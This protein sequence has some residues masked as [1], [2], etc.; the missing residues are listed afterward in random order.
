MIGIGIS[1]SLLNYPLGGF[2]LDSLEEDARAIFSIR[3]LLTSYT[4]ALVR[5]RRDNDDDE[6]DFGYDDNGDLDTVAVAAW[7]GA[8]DAF[9]VTWYDQ[10]GNGYD[11]AAS[12]TKSYQPQYIASGINSKPVLRNN[13]GASGDKLVVPDEPFRGLSAVTLCA[14]TEV[15]DGRTGYAIFGLYDVT[16]A[17]YGA[18]IAAP[19]VSNKVVFW[20]GN[21]NVNRSLDTFTLTDPHIFIGKGENEA[22]SRIYVDGTEVNYDAGKQVN[23]TTTQSGAFTRDAAIGQMDSVATSHDSD[24]DFAELIC[25]DSALSDADR[26]AIEADQSTYFNI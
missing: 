7:L 1:P 2:L 17:E 22:L 15:P 16:N 3:R 24:V 26:N 19:T 25:L 6:S 9:V 5:L 13:P 12:A 8:N 20:F 23:G 4:G 14:V 11:A 21:A 18:Y 10:S